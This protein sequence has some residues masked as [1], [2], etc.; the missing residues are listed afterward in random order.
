[1]DPRGRANRLVVEA[2]RAAYE[3]QRPSGETDTASGAG[4]S[5]T[6]TRKRISSGGAEPRR[7]RTDGTL[8]AI[9]NK[10]ATESVAHANRLRFRRP[11]AMGAGMPISESPS[12]I[13]WSWAIRSS[14]V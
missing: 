14:V 1:M 8:V 7:Y 9:N 11:A 10:I 4:I 13:H 3:I 5:G 6:L 12:A 2:S